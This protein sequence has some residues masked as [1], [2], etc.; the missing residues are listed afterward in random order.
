MSSWATAA[1]WPAGPA[2][3][4]R[5]A[6]GFRVRRPTKEVTS[7]GIKIDER[8]EFRFEFGYFPNSNHTQIRSK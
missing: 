8:F 1:G 4:A 5:L 7:S 2:A 3:L 6:A